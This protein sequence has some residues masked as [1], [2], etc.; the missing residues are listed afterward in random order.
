MIR[1]P[2]P[3]TPSAQRMAARWALRA[4]AALWLLVLVV[5]LAACGGGGD[6]DLVGP[7]EVTTP[8]VDCARPEAC[9]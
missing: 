2:N 7:P 1:R 4:L 8:R 6:D 5:L 3:M 9:R